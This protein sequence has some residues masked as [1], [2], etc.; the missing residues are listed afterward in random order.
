MASSGQTPTQQPQKSHLP[1]TM[2]IISGE[3]AGMMVP[4]YEF[5]VSSFMVQA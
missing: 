1:G 3:L 2:W 4:S 5:E